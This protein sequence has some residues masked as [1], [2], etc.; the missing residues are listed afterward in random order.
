MVFLFI[1]PKMKKGRK[2]ALSPLSEYYFLTL[3]VNVQ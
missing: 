1:I 3:T 2:L